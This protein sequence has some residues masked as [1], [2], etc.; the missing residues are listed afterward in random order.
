MTTTAPSRENSFTGVTA[1]VDSQRSSV[2]N[3]RLTSFATKIVS[4]VFVMLGAASAVFLMQ[5]LLPGDRA[6]IILNIHSGQTIARTAEEVAHINEQY[7]FTD[8][9]ITQYASYMGGLLRGDLGT[10]YQQHAPVSEIILD[11]I[12]PTL[13]LTA[14][15]LLLA[16]FINIIWTISTAGR[17]KAVG[18]IG[19]AFESI[20]ASLP[21][22]W[23]GAILLV[24]FSLNLGWFPVMGDGSWRAAVL[25]IV[26][27]AIPLAGF[28]GQSTRDEFERVLNQPFV[29][30][31]R[32]RGAS[33]LRIRTV[34]VLRHSVIPGITLSGWAFGA[35]ISSAVIVE[36]IFSRPGLGQVLMTAVDSR[37]L[38]VVGG[39]VVLI[40]FIYVLVNAAVDALYVL[41]DPRRRAQ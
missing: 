20:A 33:D 26:T 21:P 11:Q 23:L 1:P 5:T 9:L 7:G 37:D 6:A 4:A 13:Q 27:L 36:S 32:M 28:M 10:S 34:H 31:A 12:V 14:G 40:S 39:V 18:S 8:P 35:L 41:V 38:P 16:W 29:T 3:S 24:V 22:Y 15:A 25:P 17:R 19:S 30:S 2:I